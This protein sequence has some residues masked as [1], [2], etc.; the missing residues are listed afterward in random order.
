MREI[1]LDT[2]TTGLDPNDGHRVVEIGCVELVHHVPT[3]RT[4]HSF[5]NPQR[6]MPTAAF[7]I[8]GLSDA[9]LAAKPIFAAVVDDFLGFIG[10]AKLVVHNAAFDLGFI[11]AEL[12]R[13]TRDPI[14]GAGVVDTVVLA[15][16]KFPG[17]P[18]NLDAL[19]KRF[20]ISLAKRDKHGALID[21]ELLASVYIE[22]L[23]GRQPGLGLAQAMIVEMAPN[24][25]RPKERVARV[26]APTEEERA[27]HE[28]FVDSLKNP[29]WRS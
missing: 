9:F 1:A 11:N 13:V 20:S 25:R 12:K 26:V 4:Y 17:A 21:A 18:A 22:L 14:G 23:G 29:I 2:E 28:A 27:A 10:G 8:H 7:E 15:R 24:G 3:G 19:C 6:S 16:R 5:L